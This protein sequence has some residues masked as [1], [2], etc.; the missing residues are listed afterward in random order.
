MTFQQILWAINDAAEAAAESAVEAHGEEVPQRKSPGSSSTNSTT[1]A[2]SNARLP[3]LSSFPASSRATIVGT[4]P[5]CSRT[6]LPPCST[7]VP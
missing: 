6:L 2:R 7:R 5:F 4:A 3:F 1:R